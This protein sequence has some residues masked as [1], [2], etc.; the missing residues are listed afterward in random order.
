MKK[1]L[2]ESEENDSLYEMM[3][4][5][6]LCNKLPF[7]SNSV[8]ISEIG[9]L[10]KKLQKYQQRSNQYTTVEVNEFLQVVNQL[11][12]HWK[13]QLAAISKNK[14][15]KEKSAQPSN[16]VVPSQQSEKAKISEKKEPT[17]VV[18]KSEPSSKPIDLQHLSTLAK[19][20]P[21]ADST[22]SDRMDV[23]ISEPDHVSLDS[24]VDIL[25]P[26]TES[27]ESNEV[28][29]IP[30]SSSLPSLKPAVPKERKSLGMVEGARKLLAMRSQQVKAD[31]NTAASNNTTETPLDLIAEENKALPLKDQVTTPNNITVPS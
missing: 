6:K 25:E 15:Q 30:L 26:S 22:D 18:K 7:D 13:E 4:I 14:Q 27:K 3:A 17:P 5:I 11:V 2:K 8:R 12:D 19:E 24:T 31:A 16:E 29:L 23:E 9:K 10:I 21:E 28:P 20:T 1:W